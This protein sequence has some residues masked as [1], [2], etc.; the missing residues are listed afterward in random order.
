MAHDVPLIAPNEEDEIARTMAEHPEIDTMDE[1][2]RGE[3]IQITAARLNG[4]RDRPWGRK[5]RTDNPADPQL[6]T[7]AITYKRPDGLFEIID[8]ISGVDGS[9]T[10]GECGAFA[11]GEN[12]YWYAVPGDQQGGGG[13]GLEALAQRL[14]VLEL[15]VEA[16]G[17][18]VA[19]HDQRLAA[20]EAAA[21]QPLHCHGPVDLPIV[22]ESLTSL[23]A[24][25]DINVAVTP[26]EATPPDPPSDSGTS[27]AD[28]VV[29]KRVLDRIRPE[30]TGG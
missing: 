24:R 19:A 1:E 2:A 16:L 29:L 17:D 14:D 9:A 3:I 12:G 5:A 15:E 27:L 10:W 20:L 8:V 30:Q 6:N 23:R 7:D 28:V 11:D 4:H 22:L 18:Q 25:G 26:G 13:S 21:G